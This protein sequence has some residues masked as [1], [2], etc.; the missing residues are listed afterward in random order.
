MSE[1]LEFLRHKPRI[2]PETPEPES[3]A[4]WFKRVLHEALGP[5]PLDL[6]FPPDSRLNLG[7]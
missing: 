3:V 4:D 7:A 5:N 6:A 1:G 2:R